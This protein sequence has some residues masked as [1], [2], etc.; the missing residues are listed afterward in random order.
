MAVVEGELEA[1][2]RKP[3]IPDEVKAPVKPWFQ[4]PLKPEFR[5]NAKD[6]MNLDCRVEPKE[7]PDLQ[8]EWMK[9]GK[10]LDMGTRFN[11]T[12]DFGYVNLC[13]EDVQCER[14]EVTILVISQSCQQY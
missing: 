12:F 14:D 1:K 5:Y 4:P 9:N 8:I 2:S 3:P 11:S 13:L 6:T 7:D 10:P